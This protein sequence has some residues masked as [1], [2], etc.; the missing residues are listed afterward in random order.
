MKSICFSVGTDV[1]CYFNM[2]KSVFCPSWHTASHPHLIHIEESVHEHCMCA[3]HLPVL[4]LIDIC[5]QRSTRGLL[6]VRYGLAK[7]RYSCHVT[8]PMSW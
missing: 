3:S 8:Q 6:K 1:A 7:Y 2:N 5:R 4:C